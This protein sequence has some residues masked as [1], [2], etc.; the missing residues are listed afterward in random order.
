MRSL[1][2]SRYRLC[3]LD[4]LPYRVGVGDHLLALGFVYLRFL[5]VLLD[6]LIQQLVLADEGLGEGV[7]GHLLKYLQSLLWLCGQ[8]VTIFVQLYCGKVVECGGCEC[9]C[10]WLLIWMLQFLLW[11]HGDLVIF[12]YKDVVLIQVVYKVI[13]K[14]IA[15]F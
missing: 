4:L 13:Q 7:Y 5:D 9:M 15:I 12:M 11:L 6:C 3:V 2:I 1:L 14:N 10:G 8:I